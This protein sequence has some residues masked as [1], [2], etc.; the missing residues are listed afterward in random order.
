MERPQLSRPA[1][2]SRYEV[3]Q[4]VVEVGRAGAVVGQRA[5]GG[6]HAAG[7]GDGGEGQAARDSG[8]DQQEG[9]MHEQAEDRTEEHHG[10]SGEPDL[11]FRAPAGARV[12]GGGL[13]QVVAVG[14]PGRCRPGE[15]PWRCPVRQ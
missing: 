13:V 5:E 2:S 15:L 9:R 1:E 10:A 4:R 11:A 8:R 3:R 12:A 14:G 6:R 7:V